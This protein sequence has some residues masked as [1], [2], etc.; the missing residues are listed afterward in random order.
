MKMKCTHAQEEQRILRTL[1]PFFR[2]NFQRYYSSFVPPPRVTFRVII[3]KRGRARLTATSVELP[4]ISDDAR[5]SVPD[6]TRQWF[7]QSILPRRAR[8]SLT[9][10]GWHNKTVKLYVEVT[11]ADLRRPS[12]TK[13]N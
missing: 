4:Y 9:I 13:P 11:P 12:S 8:R 2:D 7:Y 6:R 1:R 5:I 10:R 3:R